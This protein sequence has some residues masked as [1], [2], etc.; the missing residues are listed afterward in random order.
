MLVAAP[1]SH[2]ATPYPIERKGARGRISLTA[3]GPL[4]THACRQPFPPAPPPQSPP[5]RTSDSFELGPSSESSSL[6]A[7]GDGAEAAADTLRPADPGRVDGGGGGGDSILPRRPT[8]IFSGSGGGA[9][10]AWE[11]AAGPGPADPFR[12]DWKHWGGRGVMP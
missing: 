9:E 8:G 3:R 4:L 2:A 6:S 1:N 11:A 7:G 5:G 10:W 12:A